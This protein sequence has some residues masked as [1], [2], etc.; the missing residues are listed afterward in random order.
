MSVLSKSPWKAQVAQSDKHSRDGNLSHNMGLNY[1][2]VDFIIILTISPKT[3]RNHCLLP[4]G[5]KMRESWDRTFLNIGK[6]WKG[7]WQPKEK[8][9]SIAL[10]IKIFKSMESSIFEWFPLTL[11]ILSLIFFFVVWFL[12][13]DF[14]V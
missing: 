7:S 3:F 10:K 4:W 14:S 11:S 5:V 12:Q 8:K 2:H 13:L 6:I 1:F 9:E